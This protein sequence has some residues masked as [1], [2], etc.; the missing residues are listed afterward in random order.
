[1]TMAVYVGDTGGAQ[2]F[3]CRVDETRGRRLLFRPAA[4]PA[5]LRMRRRVREGS[6]GLARFLARLIPEMI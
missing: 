5:L 2:L 1:S 4:L 3:G 6:G